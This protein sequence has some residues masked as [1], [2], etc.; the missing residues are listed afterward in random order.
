MNNST[1]EWTSIKN[2]QRC[3]SKSENFAK[4]KDKKWKYYLKNQ[5]KGDKHHKTRIKHP[6]LAINTFKLLLF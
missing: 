2:E 6:K 1:H 3:F 5:E 4:C